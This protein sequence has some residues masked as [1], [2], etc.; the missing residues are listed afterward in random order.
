MQ[1][2]YAAKD[3]K[4][5][6]EDGKAVGK[7]EVPRFVV[8]GSAVFDGCHRGGDVRFTISPIDVSGINSRREE[9]N[10]WVRKEKFGIHTG[11]HCW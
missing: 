4:G 7:P 11:R 2:P 3:A 10:T 1:R 6:G 8:I 5:G 9:V